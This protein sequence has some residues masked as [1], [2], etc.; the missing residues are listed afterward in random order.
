MWVAYETHVFRLGQGVSR[1]GCALW[2]ECLRCGTGTLQV[3]Q[4]TE[5]GHVASSFSSARR[6]LNHRYELVG[7]SYHRCRSRDTC[8]LVVQVFCNRYLVICAAGCCTL[9]SRGLAATRIFGQVHSRRVHRDVLRW[10][11]CFGSRWCGLAT[12]E[13]PTSKR[14]PMTLIRNYAP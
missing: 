10:S 8:A 12:M 6:R 14:S 1:R 3:L 7:F 2:P 13:P 4:V 11:C 5:I 9:S